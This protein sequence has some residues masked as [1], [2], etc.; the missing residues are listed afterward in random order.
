MKALVRILFAALILC[1]PVISVLAAENLVSRAPDL[2]TYEFTSSQVLHENNLSVNE[3]ELGDFFSD[4]MM[5]K[6]KQFTYI[7]DHNEREQGLFNN[8]EIIIMEKGRNLLNMLTYVLAAAILISIV[9]LSVMIHFGLRE[10][11]RWAYRWSWVLYAAMWLGSAMVIAMPSLNNWM[12]KWISEESLGVDS[13][14][15][16]LITPEFVKYW[17]L[18]DIGISLLFMVL[19]G[20][21]IWKVSKSKR[22][23][24]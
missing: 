11:V 20:S 12:S 2:Y 19:I 8:N 9:A 6:E 23:F 21:V 13:F 24:W 15:L 18:A 14:L 10:K 3:K 4:Y 5:G 22:I 1:I 17:L 16:K 7:A